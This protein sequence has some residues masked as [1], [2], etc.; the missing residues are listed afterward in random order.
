MDYLW[1]ILGIILIL[2]AIAGCFLPVLPGPP[3]GYVA[4]L[5]L[6]ISSNPPFTVSFLVWMAGATVVVTALDYFM[7]PLATKKFGGS[8]YGVVGSML[9][10]LAGLIVF[11]PW[12]ILIFPFIG[13]YLGERLFGP[14]K[15]VAGKAALGAV[16][17][18]VFG[19]ILKLSFTI[20]LGYYFF[21]NAPWT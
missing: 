2:S 3:L 21:V 5:L 7:P 20:V 19:V 18:Q 1:I 4:L 17:G 13:A 11:P 15:D 6:Q 9:G 16:L 8:R 14:S 12:G 10:L